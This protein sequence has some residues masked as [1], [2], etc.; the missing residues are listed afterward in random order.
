MPNLLRRSF[1]A[2]LLVLL[3]PATVWAQP[4]LQ[5][6]LQAQQQNNPQLMAI[7]GVEATGVSVDAAGNAVVKV[8]LRDARVGGVPAQV[9]GVKVVQSVSG[10]IRAWADTK[11]TARDKPDKPG[12]G[13]GNDG[14]GGTDPKDRFNRAVPIGV[15]MGAFKPEQNN[16]CFA[17]TLG[18]RLKATYGDNSVARFILSNNHVMA[19]ENNGNRDWDVIIQ[20]GTLDNGCVYDSNDQIGILRDFVEIKFNGDNLMDAAIASTDT[21]L[22]GVATPANGYG[23]PTSTVATAT[24]G[25]LVKKYGRTTGYT[26]G[27]VDAINVSVNVGYSAGTARFVDQIIIVGLV[28]RGKRLVDGSFSDS[29]DSGSLIVTQEGNNPTG[30]LFAGNSSVTVANP[31]AAVLAEFSVRENAV[32]EVDDGN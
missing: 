30:L 12:N 25:M 9:G 14:G 27:Y 2:S 31:I 10:E 22:T 24:P 15:S 21:T 7:N 3:I 28:K 23:T 16:Y 6:A 26:E 19:D 29:G 5:K 4:G 11:V 8:Y 13:N 1:L 17:G 18:C 32:V 20:P